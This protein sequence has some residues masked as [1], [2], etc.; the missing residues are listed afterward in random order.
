M[1]EKSSKIIKFIEYAM[2]NWRAGGNSLI[3]IE[4]QRGI[5]LGDVLSPLLF[6]IAMVP[7]N[8]ILTHWML[9]NL[10]MGR[11]IQPPNVHRRPQTGKNEKELEILMQAVRIFIE[12]IRMEFGI[13]KKCTMLIM[14]SRKRQMIE[15]IEKESERIRK[16][17]LYKFLEILEADAIK[18]VEMKEKM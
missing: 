7:L 4:I 13:E 16:R 14:K 2:K 6:M 10:K 11:K 12:D 3:E 15:G 5:F 18:H 8:H 1:F 9:Q 17:K